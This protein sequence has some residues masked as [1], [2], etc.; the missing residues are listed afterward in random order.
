[1]GSCCFGRDEDDEACVPNAAPNGDDG[2]GEGDEK[3]S[4]G[5]PEGVEVPSE[6]VAPLA[7]PLPL[8]SLPSETPPRCSSSA[9]ASN[10][11]RSG[12][13]GLRLMAGVS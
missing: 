7:D 11:M 1:M 5:R 13:D 10:E 12:L 3:R 6:G 9:K 8:A 4:R 2:A